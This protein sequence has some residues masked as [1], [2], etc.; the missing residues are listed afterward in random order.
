MTLVSPRQCAQMIEKGVWGVASD[1]SQCDS[2]GGMI[3]RWD[4]HLKFPKSHGALCL[5]CAAPKRE[6]RQ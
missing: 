1:Y 4:W 5:D 2:C 6:V 3:V